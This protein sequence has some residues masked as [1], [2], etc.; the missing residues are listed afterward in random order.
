MWT[1][2]I[3]TNDSCTRHERDRAAKAKDCRYGKLR[4]RKPCCVCLLRGASSP[5]SP[6]KLA[7]VPRPSLPPAP[8]NPSRPLWTPVPEFPLCKAKA[9]PNQ[10]KQATMAIY[11]MQRASQAFMPG[12]GWKILICGHKMWKLLFVQAIDSG[13][14]PTFTRDHIQPIHDVRKICTYFSHTTG[15]VLYI[16][17]M[18]HIFF[19]LIS[20]LIRSMLV[21]NLIPI[22][23]YLNRSTT[24]HRMEF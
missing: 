13:E 1:W 19:H 8:G 24:G 17:I 18:R 21:L 4:L 23:L 15:C 5:T 11:S 12:H 22:F 6:R 14:T 9:Q 16:P 2:A 10:A 3:V 7:A 20:V